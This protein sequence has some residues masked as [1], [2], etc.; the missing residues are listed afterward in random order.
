VRREVIDAVN[1]GQRPSLQA[2]EGACF[3]VSLEL[4][5]SHR[6]TA[7]TYARA[8]GL[9]GEQGMVEL[10]AVNGY[11]ALLAMQMNMMQTPPVATEIPLIPRSQLPKR[12]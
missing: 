10:T 4:H 11:Y 9:L 6:V 3:D 7:E 1:R 8:V 12:G 2:D 5:R